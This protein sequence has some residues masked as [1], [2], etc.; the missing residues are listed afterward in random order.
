MTW[1]RPGR[2]ITDQVLR[3]EMAAAELGGA[4]E[5]AVP[6]GPR[7]TY[8][9]GG[10]ALVAVTVSSLSQLEDVAAIVAKTGVDTLVV[11]RGSNLLVADEGFLGLAIFLSGSF[12]SVSFDS[13]SG[14]G[15]SGDGV[16]G[17]G[18][19]VIAG[20]AARLPVVARQT[21]TQGLIGFEWAVGV[22]GSIGGAVRMNAGGHG[23]DMARS[24]VSAQVADL[25]RGV[26]ETWDANGL[27]FG[28]RSSAIGPQ[29]VVI[30]ATLELEPGDRKRSMVLLDEIVAWRRA[31]QPGGSNAGSVFTN[32]PGDS[33]GR[34]IDEAGGRGLRVGSAAVSM[35]HANFIQ[36]D[37]GGCA[38]DVWSLMNQ[39]RQLVVKAGGPD[40]H[41]ETT[42]VGFPGLEVGGP[43]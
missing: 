22:P 14:D 30:A 19:R 4:A 31:H 11:G 5:R 34:L 12:D 3:C 24:V 32:P 38:A 36:C 33:A 41:P 27:R 42:C 8:R 2:C 25:A 28:Y 16:S 1:P 35:K 10:S 6:L 17:E 18:L 20:G 37:P 43:C 40:L 23:S 39:L 29:H 21:V 13:V 15:V 7:T 26:V 9:V